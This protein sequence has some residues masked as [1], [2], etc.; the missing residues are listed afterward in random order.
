M[1]AVR[2]HIFPS[3]STLNSLDVSPLNGFDFFLWSQ[4]P[5]QLTLWTREVT[6][7]NHYLNESFAVRAYA[8]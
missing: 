6:V 5:C 3:V 4:I 2:D 1:I 8:C 7:D